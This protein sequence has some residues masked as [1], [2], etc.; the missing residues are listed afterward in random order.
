MLGIL[1]T[2]TALALV[3]LVLY[4]LAQLPKILNLSVRPSL[5]SRLPLLS[6]WQ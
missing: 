3:A 6:C 1:G 5:G 4:G 2:Y